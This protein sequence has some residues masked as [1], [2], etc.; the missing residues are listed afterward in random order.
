MIRGNSMSSQQRSTPQ[1]AAKLVWRAVTVALCAGFVWGIVF[2]QLLMMPDLLR[3]GLGLFT[4]AALTLSTYF[5]T[6][7]ALN[8]RRQ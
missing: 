8:S 6:R 1:D 5:L 3:G 7:A 4:A 2:F